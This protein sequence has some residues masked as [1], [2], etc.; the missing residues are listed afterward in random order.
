MED[1]ILNQSD[2][3][4]LVTQLKDK[5]LAKKRNEDLSQDEID[6]VIKDYETLTNTNLSQSEIDRIIKTF[7]EE[8][9]PD[10]S[11]S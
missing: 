4:K 3:D 11:A 1:E 7:D 5:K 8:F 6:A 9:K 10:L 2:I